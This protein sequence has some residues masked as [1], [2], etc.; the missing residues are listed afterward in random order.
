MHT[1]PRASWSR[2]DRAALELSLLD[3]ARARLHAWDIYPRFDLAA[4]L[5]VESLPALMQEIVL[6]LG[7]PWGAAFG[8]GAGLS[9]PVRF[10]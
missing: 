9:L 5:F 4:R 10:H 1:Y 6:Q 7:P 2:A 8:Q 3:D